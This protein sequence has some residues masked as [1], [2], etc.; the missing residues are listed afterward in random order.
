MDDWDHWHS[1]LAV[2]EEGSLSAAARRLG[3]TQPTLGRHI[4]SLEDAVGSALFLRAPSG[5]LPTDLARTLLPEARAMAAAAGAL[6]R[7]ASAPEAADAGRVRLAAS[8]IVGLYV[9]PEILSTFVAAHPLIGID[10]V[11]SNRNEDLL[12]LDA[13][14]AVRMVRPTQG[15]LVAQALGTVRLGLYASKRYAARRGLPGSLVALADHALIGPESIQGLAG[16]S[17]AGRPIDPEMF[18]HRCET[19]AAQLAMV[20]AGLGIGVCQQGI[21]R[22][23]PAL[24]PVLPDAVEFTLTPWLVMHEDLR[25]SRRIRLLYDHLAG[26]LARLWA[27]GQRDAL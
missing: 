25:A 21:A 14:L 24:I 18:A 12:R 5:L 26:G 9:L 20:E 27:R 1:F 16:Q 17:L 2:M 11:L 7:R 19:D 10:L 15:A 6:R 8:E 13:D 4:A 23:R 22:T 3:L